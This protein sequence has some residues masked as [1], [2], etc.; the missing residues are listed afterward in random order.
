MP[1]YTTESGELSSDSRVI[2]TFLFFGVRA[3]LGFSM[4][5]RLPTES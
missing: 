3:G 2:E 5:L 1:T 4:S